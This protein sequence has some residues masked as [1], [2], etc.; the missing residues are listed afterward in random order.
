M[1]GSIPLADVLAQNKVVGNLQLL[2]KLHY[3][4]FRIP[5]GRASGAFNVYLGLFVVNFYCHSLL[6]DLGSS[7]QG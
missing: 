5:Y 2:Y 1:V 6:W 4:N 7:L 3:N